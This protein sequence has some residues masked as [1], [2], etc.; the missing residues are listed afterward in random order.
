MLIVNDLLENKSYAYD[1]NFFK[2]SVY[3]KIVQKIL[4][5][6]LIMQNNK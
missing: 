1:L 6:L 5:I 2:N 3:C 4:I